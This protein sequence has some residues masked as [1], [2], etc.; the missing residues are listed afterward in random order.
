[1]LTKDEKKILKE[2]EIN[3]NKNRQAISEFV[4][5]LDVILIEFNDEQKIK[6]LKK[7]EL[8]IDRR[9]TNINIDLVEQLLKF[10][11]LPNYF[12]EY[13]V[14]VKIINK[15]FT[16][17]YKLQKNINSILNFIHQ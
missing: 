16:E 17:S 8:F 1:M 11:Q 14:E 15:L 4:G 2:I 10:E 6:L 13:L 12:K 7:S 9:G 5:N 3:F